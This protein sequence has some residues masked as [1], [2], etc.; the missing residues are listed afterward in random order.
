MNSLAIYSPC[1]TPI[2]RS[3]R[4]AAQLSRFLLLHN[5]TMLE[6]P[7]GATPRLAAIS[8]GMTSATATPAK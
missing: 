1:S 8:I 2:A 7:P 5:A 4:I 6:F 3:A